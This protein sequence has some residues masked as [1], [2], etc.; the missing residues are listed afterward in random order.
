MVLNTVKDA[1]LKGKR[2]LIRVD[3]NVPVKN[4]V[5]TDATRIKAALPT[6]NY[7]LDGGASL[8]VMSH[9]GRPKGQKNMDFSMAPIR[10]EFEKLLGKPVKLAPDV[11]GEEVEKEVKALKP[12]EV[13]LLENVRFYPDEEKNGEEFAKTLASYGDL[14][15]NDAFGTAHRAHASTE[16]VSH[17]LPAYAG[18]LI[19]KEVK[20]M[21]PL[22]ENPEHPFVAVIGGSKVS[23][24]I[25]V[26]ESLVKTCDTIVIG[27]G[28][29]Y[30]FLKVLGHSVGTSLVEDDY[31]ETAKAF[32][33]AAE[34]KGVK[35]ILPVDHVCADKF[36]ENATP[37]AVDSVDIP[38]GLMGLDIGPKTV[39]LIVS[40]MKS[41]KNVVW[42]GPM[43]VFEFSAFAK[44]TEA[45]AKALAESD[46]ISVVGGGDSVAAINKFGLAS[47]ISHVSTGGGASLEFLE[48]KVLPGI[49]A[50]EKQGRRPYIAGN[51]KMNL[52]PSEAKK[53]AAELAAAYKESGA[54]CKCMIACPFVDLPGVVEAVKGSDIIVAAENMAD[55]KSGAYTGE[56]SPLMLQDLG[57]NTVILGH[58]ERRQYYGETNEVVNGKVLLALECGMDVD[59]CVG[60][61]LEEREGGK[62]EEVLTAQLEVGLKGVKPEEM[63]KITIAYEPVWA[64]GTGKTATPE[65]ADN[66]H[67]FIRETVA[68]L[69]SKD[70]A[71][72]LIIQYGGSV[73]AENVEA[74]MAK[75]NIDGALVGGA[76]LSVDKFLPII[77]FNK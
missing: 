54:D 22:L 33:A 11:I 73:K 57:V 19:E 62:L 17:F 31:Q 16:G 63:A 25:S 3:F 1:D 70:I 59:L 60:E 4:G 52:V 75:E 2:V 30:T 37:V 44:G 48:G 39:A 61:T 72:K 77:A 45:V 74:L 46:A 28:M 23:S 50:L 12:G 15:V 49:K 36:D 13:L 10:A 9:Y 24:K 40:E 68:R 65:D 47:Q 21:A 71:E 14:Y 35:V 18:F 55:H 38:E 6:I 69:Y 58:S 20:F 66:A 26:L 67:A 43:G 29:A 53:Y 34:K 5:V 27:G 32:L 42:N 7:I 41:A 64:I 76:S 56:V 51:W 8:V